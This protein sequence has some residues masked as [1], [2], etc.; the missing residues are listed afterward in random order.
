M[1]QGLTPSF[2]TI[3]QVHFVPRERVTR[4][5]A[6]FGEAVNTFVR[7]GVGSGK[8]FPSPPNAGNTLRDEVE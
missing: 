4:I 7:W 6:P 8:I 2:P 1:I 5:E 3:G